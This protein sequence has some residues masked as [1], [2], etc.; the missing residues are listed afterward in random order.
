MD[1]GTKEIEWQ[2][3]E[4]VLVRKGQSSPLP[5]RRC[6]NTLANKCFLEVR[7]GLQLGLMFS[8]FS[9]CGVKAVGVFLYMK[10]TEKHSSS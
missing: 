10:V 5:R 7:E 9:S 1:P 8:A 3:A 4:N 6:L 2:C